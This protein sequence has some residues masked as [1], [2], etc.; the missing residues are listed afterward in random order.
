MLPLDTLTMEIFYKEKIC[1]ILC[2]VYYNGDTCIGIEAKEGSSVKNLFYDF[3]MTINFFNIDGG[4]SFYC[5]N[6]FRLLSWESNS[7]WCRI[8]LRKLAAGVAKK[9]GTSYNPTFENVTCKAL[10]NRLE[11]LDEKNRI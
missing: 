6:L 1:G 4:K 2:I 5:Q 3:D 7:A 8:I 11:V 10:A 9:L